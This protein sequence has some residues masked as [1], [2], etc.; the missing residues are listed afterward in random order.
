MFDK[1]YVICSSRQTDNT[2]LIA[3][4]GQHECTQQELG[5]EILK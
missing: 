3:Y 5:L 1:L 2:I 4:T